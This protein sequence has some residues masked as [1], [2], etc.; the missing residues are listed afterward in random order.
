[1]V[2]HSN[3]QLY[4]QTL[5]ME[6]AFDDILC[7]YCW[8]TEVRGERRYA[9]WALIAAL[10]FTSPAAEEAHVGRGEGSLEI[11]ISNARA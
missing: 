11:S 4:I 5:V 1:M 8:R 6:C 7:R 10:A 3:R 2:R 9:D